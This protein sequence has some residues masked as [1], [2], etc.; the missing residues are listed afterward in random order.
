MRTITA[1]G[2]LFITLFLVMIVAQN[3][4]IFAQKEV[5]VLDLAYLQ[6]R[7]NPIRLDLLLIG[8]FA[9][10]FL[11]A[12]ILGAPSRLKGVVERRKLRKEVTRTRQLPVPTSVSHEPQ[13]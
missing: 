2:F 11:L 3:Q 1:L 4:A 9:I 5:L 10:G 8:G 13:S 12:T 6:I 7:F